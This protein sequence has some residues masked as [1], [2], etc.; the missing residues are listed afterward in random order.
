MDGSGWKNKSATVV[1]PKI[2]MKEQW[3]EQANVIFAKS[4]MNTTFFSVQ[5]VRLRMG[6]F[7]KNAAWLR[8]KE[9]QAARSFVKIAVM[10]K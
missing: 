7:V 6:M 5:C 1:K 9:I 2:K 3:S 4:T 10:K 8:Q